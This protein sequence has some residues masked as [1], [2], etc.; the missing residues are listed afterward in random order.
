MSNLEEE[1][2][3]LKAKVKA[4]EDLLHSMPIMNFLEAVQIE[5]GYQKIIWPEQDKTKSAWDWFWALGYLSGK[6]LAAEKANDKVKYLHHLVT[7]AALLANWH[8]AVVSQ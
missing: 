3:Q 1:N 8:E 7:S 6:A 2:A 4:L 5:A